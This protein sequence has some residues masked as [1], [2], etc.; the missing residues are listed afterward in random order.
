MSNLTEHF[1]IQSYYLTFEEE[2]LYKYLKKDERFEFTN[3][4]EIWDVKVKLLKRK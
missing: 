1:I 3:E 2:E 4:E